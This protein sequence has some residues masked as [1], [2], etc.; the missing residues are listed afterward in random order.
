VYDLQ[1]QQWAASKQNPGVLPTGAR[2]RMPRSLFKSTFSHPPTSAAAETTADARVFFCS[3]NWWNL[4]LD[5]VT[6]IFQFVQVCVVV[7]YIQNSI[8]KNDLF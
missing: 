5:T 6:A 2:V 7:F 3:I 4:E 1:L 8:F